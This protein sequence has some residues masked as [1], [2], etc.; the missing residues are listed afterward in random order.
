MIGQ[1]EIRHEIP[2]RDGGL[3][4]LCRHRQRSIRTVVGGSA[5]GLY[6]RPHGAGETAQRRDGNGAE[7]LER[8]LQ[9][10]E[11]LARDLARERLDSEKTLRRAAQAL[12]GLRDSEARLGESLAQLVSEISQARERQQAQAATVTSCAE[13]IAQRTEAL[14]ALL[15]R[16]A[17]IGTEAAEVTRLVHGVATEPATNG[18]AAADPATTF[19]E[20]ERR[21]SH[22]AE[23]AEGLS[24][25][26]LADSF[27]DLAKQADGLRQQVLGSLNKVRLARKSGG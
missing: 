19:D 23:E 16:W 26:A 12:T 18:G 6:D 7:A 27:S 20:V 8:E 3:V 22:L 1:L 5:G 13:Q 21:L 17:A 4:G 11:A 25:A 14:G 2:P 15:A 24:T 9:R 10:Y